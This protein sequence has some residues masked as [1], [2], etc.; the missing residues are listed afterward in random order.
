MEL[1]DSIETLAIELIDKVFFHKAREIQYQ[2]KD[3]NF[4]RIRNKNRQKP[5][6]WYNQQ[7]HYNRTGNTKQ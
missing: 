2:I 5:Y 7:P 1:K 6:K 4:I 3:H